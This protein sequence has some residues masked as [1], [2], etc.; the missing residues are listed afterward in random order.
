MPR[1]TSMKKSRKSTK[2]DEFGIAGMEHMMES[3][4][5]TIGKVAVA[6]MEIGLAGAVIGMIR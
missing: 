4:T 6:G 1:K 2:K 3:T 5:A